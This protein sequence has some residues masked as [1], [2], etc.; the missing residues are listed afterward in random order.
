MYRMLFSLITKFLSI[1]GKHKLHLFQ[2]A[3]REFTA[4]LLSLI[5]NF[6]RAVELHED[7]VQST[8]SPAELITGCFDGIKVAYP[9]PPP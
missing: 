3:D 6:R 1:I 9:T 5:C 2:K 8:Q 7:L 4:S